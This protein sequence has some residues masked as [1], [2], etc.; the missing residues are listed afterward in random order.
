MSRGTQSENQR[1]MVVTS[2][3]ANG[4]TRPHGMVS[5]SLQPGQVPS[6]A[7]SSQSRGGVRAAV[8]IL[9]VLFSLASIGTNSTYLVS[10]GTTSLGMT[11]LGVAALSYELGLV[12][13]PTVLVHLWRQRDFA[14]CFWGFL[15]TFVC[16]MTAVYAATGFVNANFGDTEARRGA[17]VKSRSSLTVELDR[18]QADRNAI[19]V[20]PTSQAAIDLAA[21]AVK[22]DCPI[23]N[24]TDDCKAKRSKHQGL[25]EQIA[26]NEKAAELDTKIP[27][28]QARLDVAPTTKWAD[29]QIEGV[30]LLFSGTST[31]GRHHAE[32]GRIVQFIVL[33]IGAGLLWSFFTALGVMGRLPERRTA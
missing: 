7:Q 23:W 33:P 28:L 10:Q 2:S 30:V 19:T 31:I 14:L 25:V 15:F 11:C 5:P 20:I 12:V 22:R 29:P 26:R 4:V 32:V 3:Q 1:L 24:K 8:A 16:L 6:V 21:V 13:M 17:E 18:M 27:A 9:A